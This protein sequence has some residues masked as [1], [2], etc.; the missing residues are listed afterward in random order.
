[1][2]ALAIDDVLLAAKVLRRYLQPTPLYSYP[3]L[4]RLLGAE[5]F[6]KHENHA[7]VGSFKARGALNAL[8]AHR[9]AGRVVASSAGNHG[10]GLAFGAGLLGMQARHLARDVIGTHQKRHQAVRGVAE[11]LEEL[12]D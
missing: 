5:I 11:P 8:V 6:V 1:M 7:P 2:D 10:M 9:A 4:D 12:S 3:S